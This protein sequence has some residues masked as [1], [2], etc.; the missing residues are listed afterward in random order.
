MGKYLVGTSPN[1]DDQVCVEGWG[2]GDFIG[3]CEFS[4]SLGYCP[5][6]ACVC[7]KLG[8]QPTLPESTGVV[9]YPAAGKDANYPGLC[10]FDCTYGYCPSTACGTVSVPLTIPTVSPFTHD[11]CVAGIGEGELTGLCSFSCNYGYCPIYNCTCTATGPLNN[12]PAQNTSIIGWAPYIEDNGL[13]SF[14]CTRDYCPSPVC[15]DMI[16]EDDPCGY[17]DDDSEECSGTFPCDFSINYSSLDA[18]EADSDNFDP[19]CV[20]YYMLGAL[21]G[22]LKATLANYTNIANTADYDKDFEEYTKYM[23]EQVEPQLY[24]FMNI[25]YVDNKPSGLGNQYFECTYNA[26][27][28]NNSKESC[29]NEYAESS[30]QNHIIYY[31]IVDRECFFGNLTDS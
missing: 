10:S 15:L 17:V 23:I 22:E 3:L 30:V 11:T 9:G 26:N 2:M 18:L 1:L 7:T 8:P 21:Y 16:P 4:C 5:V 6:G 31:D 29:P 13:C 14:A 24:Y 27:G 20:D 25:S 12:P 28:R 19:Y